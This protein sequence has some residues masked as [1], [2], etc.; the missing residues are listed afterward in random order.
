MAPAALRKLYAVELQTV[1][2]ARACWAVAPSR[3]E[4]PV[5]MPRGT[6][7]RGLRLWVDPIKTALRQLRSPLERAS[8]LT[9]VSGQPSTRSLRHAYGTGPTPN[10]FFCG[11]LSRNTAV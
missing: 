3:S 2:V 5:D 1:D 9:A 8:A 6:Y 7:H 11:Q 10:C 4:L